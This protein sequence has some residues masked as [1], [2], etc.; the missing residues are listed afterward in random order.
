MTD[1]EFENRVLRVIKIWLDRADRIRERGTTTDVRGVLVLALKELLALKEG[2]R[3]D[4]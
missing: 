3:D 1:K 4:S 2:Q